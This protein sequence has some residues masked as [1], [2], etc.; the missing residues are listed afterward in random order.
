MPNQKLLFYCNS[1]I[2]FIP[3]IIQNV[4]TYDLREL[5]DFINLIELVNVNENGN[6][7]SRYITSSLLTCWYNIQSVTKIIIS[8]IGIIVF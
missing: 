3:Q 5:Q 6:F 4:P 8:Q 1:S 2:I 7:L